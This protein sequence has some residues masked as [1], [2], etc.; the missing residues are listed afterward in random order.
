MARDCSDSRKEAQHI[1]DEFLNA[2]PNTKPGKFLA[3]LGSQQN[4]Y[5][6]ITF[7]YE[8]EDRM[9][10]INQVVLATG[11][12]WNYLSHHGTVQLGVRVCYHTTSY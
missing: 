7:Y 8:E 3:S 2:S 9:D 5:G 12:H 10:I 4:D 1:T 11:Y 6:P